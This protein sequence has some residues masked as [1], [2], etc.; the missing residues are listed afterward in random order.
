MDLTNIATAYCMHTL[1]KMDKAAL[2]RQTVIESFRESDIK[3]ID[4][5]K[6]MYK[7]ESNNDINKFIFDAFKYLGNIKQDMKKRFNEMD[8]EELIA[9]MNKRE[10]TDEFCKKYIMSEEEM[11]NDKFFQCG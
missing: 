9:V 3:L 2:A 5:M 11:K 1:L 4:N 10:A 7:L 6:K 8:K